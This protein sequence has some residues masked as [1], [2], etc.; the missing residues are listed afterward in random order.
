MY[1][2]QKVESIGKSDDLDMVDENYHTGIRFYSCMNYTDALNSFNQ[3]IRENPN[4]PKAWY[5][6]GSTYF[7]MALK[8]K[9]D[10]SR[11]ELSK[12]SKKYFN[13]SQ[14]CYHVAAG[15]AK[16]RKVN[17][18]EA[19]ALIGEGG[20]F[21]ELRKYN[22][23]IDCFS[24]AANIL[25]STQIDQLKFCNKPWYSK[26]IS[27]YELGQIYK[28]KNLQEANEYFGQARDSFQQAIEKDPHDAAAYEGKGSALHKLNKYEEAIFCFNETIRIHPNSPKAWY[29]KGLS[30]HNLGRFNEAI[31]CYVA[32]LS[33]HQKR[34]QKD[35]NSW[36]DRGNALYNTGRY[37]EAKECYEAALTES[38]TLYL[39][40]YAVINIAWCLIATGKQDILNNAIRRLDNDVLNKYS[41]IL[42][43]GRIESDG[44]LDLDEVD[45]NIVHSIINAL[46]IKGFILYKQNKCHKALFYIDKSLKICSKYGIRNHYPWYYKGLILHKLE[47]YNEAIDSYLEAMDILEADPNNKFAEVYV[48]M[49]Y[50]YKRNNDYKTAIKNLKK[51]LEIK[52]TLV[53]AHELLAELESSSVNDGLQFLKFWT[54]SKNRKVLAAVLISAAVFLV[55]YPMSG[56]MIIDKDIKQLRL[57]IN[58][59]L[60]GFIATVLLLPDIGKAK[61][62][63]FEFDR[64]ID[65]PGSKTK[66]DLEYS[67][68]LKE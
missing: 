19:A 14:Y 33:I 18:D 66:L 64:I 62:G 55:A 9:A 16:E 1:M 57:E 61:V 65:Q 38:N 59:I 54:A 41:N 50:S 8:S 35:P 47:K 46:D 42:G 60:V 53:T 17:T 6:K 40:F 3:V 20:C 34:G 48:A 30:L 43:L 37:E 7:A 24:K 26:G 5:M 13:F 23:A 10:S 49:A 21:H 2:A 44:K 31:D 28:E 11:E 68:I 58:L 51:A 25:G 36:N 15:I 45:R 27:L 67:P 52:P 56:Y 63:P 12:E 29:N 32:S 4:C 22:R 39:K